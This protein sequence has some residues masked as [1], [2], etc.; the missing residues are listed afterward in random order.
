MQLSDRD[1]RILGPLAGRAL[2][3]GS[4][5]PA[6]RASAPACGKMSEGQTTDNI[7]ASGIQDPPI[8]V[9]F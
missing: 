5:L 3:T 2:G 4:D 1:D 8:Y 9:Q 7:T 6:C